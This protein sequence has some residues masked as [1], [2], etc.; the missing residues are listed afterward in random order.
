MQIALLC[1]QSASYTNTL[2][3][4][5]RDYLTS[6]TY[7]HTR[8]RSRRHPYQ[9]PLCPRAS[10]TSCAP[11]PG[12]GRLGRWRRGGHPAGH[13]GRAVVGHV[14][15]GEGIPAACAAASGW[16]VHYAPNC[17][18]HPYS[19][20]HTLTRHCALCALLP[21][22]LLCGSRGQQ[23]PNTLCPVRGVQCSVRKKCSWTVLQPP[24][25]CGV[26]RWR[27][28]YQESRGG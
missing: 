7:I 23:Y 18:V 17:P 22:A 4:Y 11:S 6:C 10:R 25:P 15:G 2:P 21:C 13:V 8:Q 28:A 19:P 14:Q 20:Q 26:P 3:D 16:R 12:A 1:M 9:T 24:R 27:I 5:I